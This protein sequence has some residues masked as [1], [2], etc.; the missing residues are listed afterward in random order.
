MPPK[1]R[2]RPRFDFDVK[3]M[4]IVDV[5]L[6]MLLLAV[7]IALKVI[8]LPPHRCPPEYDRACLIDRAYTEGI[9]ANASIWAMI[10][11][12]NPIVFGYIGYSQ[13][14]KNQ[15]VGVFFVFSLLGLLLNC[16][17]F[18]AAYVEAMPALNMVCSSDTATCECQLR[19]LT[20]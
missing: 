17:G 19:E 7:G 13:A 20:L 15:A 3:K 6:G 1:I 14:K 10:A 16:L 11:T 4:A 18:L 8:S 9:F 2:R 12:F 5:L